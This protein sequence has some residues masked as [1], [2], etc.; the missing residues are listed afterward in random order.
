VQLQP[1]RQPETAIAAR[2]GAGSGGSLSRASVPR[3]S[4]RQNEE[5]LKLS[6]RILQLT[7]EVRSYADTIVT[8]R[9]QNKELLELSRQTLAMTKDM[10]ARPNSANASGSA[11]G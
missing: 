7:K 8:E 5:L 2:F 6:R 1:T 9:D 11:S 4:T 10:H 3:R